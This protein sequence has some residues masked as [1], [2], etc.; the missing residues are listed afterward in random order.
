M[1]NLTSLK[2]FAHISLIFFILKVYIIWSR[3]I[4]I[5]L[6]PPVWYLMCTQITV[7]SGSK[8]KTHSPIHTPTVLAKSET[9][10]IPRLFVNIL[11]WK[12]VGNP[13]R[14]YIMSVCWAIS[15]HR[16]IIIRL[17]H[18]EHAMN[19]QWPIYKNSHLGFISKECD[20]IFNE[21][22]TVI[23]TYQY[24]P[25]HWSQST[26]LPRSYSETAQKN[27]G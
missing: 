17:S 13:T 14:S 23:T 19:G 2:I 16:N 8:F 3:A 20:T 22:H 15:K 18:T 11:F 27:G 7:P 5:Y 6:P 26:F 25:A 12:S 1:F 9:K 24:I 21:R 10:L 4:V